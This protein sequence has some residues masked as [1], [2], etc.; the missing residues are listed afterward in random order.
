MVVAWRAVDSSWA[1]VIFAVGAVV[2]S[3][4]ETDESNTAKENRSQTL[5]AA[6]RLKTFQ[7]H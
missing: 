2:S 6:L 4:V 3:I 5:M 7:Q 1:E